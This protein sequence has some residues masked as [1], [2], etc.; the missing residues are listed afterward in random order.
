MKRNYQHLCRRLAYR[1]VAFAALIGSAF[2]TLDLPDQLDV[3]GGGFVNQPLGPGDW[4][5]HHIRARAGGKGRAPIQADFTDISITRSGRSDTRSAGQELISWEANVNIFPEEWAKEPFCAAVKPIERSQRTR[6]HA[7]VNRAIQKYPE[8]LI[9]ETLPRVFVVGELTF[10]NKQQ[11]SGTTSHRAVYLVVKPE[12]AGYTDHFI[13][14]TFHREYSSLLLNIYLKHLDQSSW[15]AINP[16][17]FRYLGASSWER[18]KGKDG[19]ATAIENG[20]TS[21]SLQGRVG[22]LDYGFLTEYSKSSIENDFNEYAAALFME[23]SGLRELAE[24]HPAVAKKRNA[25]IQFYSSIVP[26]LNA[27]YFMNIQPE[28]RTKPPSGAEGD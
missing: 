13:E 23:K 28:K 15:E 2:A 1:M 5:F 8:S 25:T 19:G 9:K 22:Y 17:G 6:A 26:E 14:A 10:F 21:L 24:K 11:F 7:L 18:P 3:S 27:N 4:S 16:K 12:A 20:K